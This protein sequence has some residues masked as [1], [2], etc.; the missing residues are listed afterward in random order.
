MTALL[1]FNSFFNP[2][3][4]KRAYNMNNLLSI[5]CTVDDFCKE[6]LPKLESKSLLI[7]TKKRKKKS[8]LSYSEI[9]TLLI[10]FHI[11]PAFNC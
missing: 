10:C 9:M 8:R 4:H 7:S 2:K 6:I 3:K 1:C 11:T 5:F